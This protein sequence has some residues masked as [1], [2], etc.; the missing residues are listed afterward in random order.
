MW[1]R[2]ESGKVKCTK[3]CQSWKVFGICVPTTLEYVYCCIL[4]CLPMRA[5]LLSMCTYVYR[6]THVKQS[7]AWVFTQVFKGMTQSILGPHKMYNPHTPGQVGAL[8]GGVQF[9]STSATMLPGHFAICTSLSPCSRQS[10][11]IHV[12]Y[13]TFEFDP[14][15]HRRPRN[16]TSRQKWKLIVWLR[17]V[18]VLRRTSEQLGVTCRVYCHHKTPHQR[19]LPPWRPCGTWC[20]RRSRRRGISQ[21]EP[22]RGLVFE[23]SIFRL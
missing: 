5:A 6:C 19:W 11:M 10:A 16:R 13:A 8:S 3:R 23:I 9:H 18:F 1:C 17:D 22:S 2:D 21:N 7:V 14:I 20:R 12:W 15:F 4:Y